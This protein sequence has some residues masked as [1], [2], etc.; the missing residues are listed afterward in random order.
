M[1]RIILAVGS[2]IAYI[3]V[4]P[5][6]YPHVGLSLGAL[7]FA[8]IVVTAWLYGL[9]GGVAIGIAFS[10]INAALFPAVT[11]PAKWLVPTFASVFMGAFVGYTSNLRWALHEKQRVLLAASE[12]DHLTGLLNRPTF[13]A[14]MATVLSRPGPHALLYLDLDGFKNV[15][16]AHGHA[17][18]DELLREMSARLAAS[19]RTTDI[20]ARIG[21]DEFAIGVPDLSSMKEASRLAQRLVDTT[22]GPRSREGRTGPITVSIGIAF[23]PRDGTTPD[24]LL[25]TADGAMYQVKE[26]GKNG[27]RCSG[28]ESPEA[29][30]ASIR[31]PRTSPPS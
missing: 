17:A 18:G 29:L 30:E 13:E 10:I 5:L 27:Y 14:R 12:R 15:N 21:G 6:L 16:D 4:F 23:A 25:R 9:W 31:L 8:P 1:L 24:D 2:S 7:S 26:C 3:L 22:S 28:G 19:L 20:V 11:S